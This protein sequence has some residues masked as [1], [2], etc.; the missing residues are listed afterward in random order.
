MNQANG[1]CSTTNA[2]CSTAFIIGMLSMW[3]IISV[4]WVF[5]ANSEI[6]LRMDIFS[7]PDT[8]PCSGSNTQSKILV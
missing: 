7:D 6:D 1:I 5:L 2:K 3:E 8:N 4:I